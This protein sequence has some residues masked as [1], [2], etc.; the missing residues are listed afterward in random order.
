MKENVTLWVATILTIAAIVGVV[1]LSAYHLAKWGCKSYGQETNREIK[2]A[3]GQCYVKHD[4]AW[5]TTR[6]L[7][8]V[9]LLEKKQQSGVQ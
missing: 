6:E 7:G 5:F 4:G 9:Q 8:Y 2:F 1:F 3:A